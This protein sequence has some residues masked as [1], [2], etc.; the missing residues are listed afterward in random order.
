MEGS[1]SVK[2]IKEIEQ[3]LRDYPAALELYRTKRYKVKVKYEADVERVILVEKRSSR[4]ASNNVTKTNDHEKNKQSNNDTST[5]VNKTKD[6]VKKPKD[7]DRSRSRTHSQDRVLPTTSVS[8]NNDAVQTTTSSVR[9]ASNTQPKVDHQ[10]TPSKDR[11][12][13]EASQS[14]QEPQ[15]QQQE[16]RR[17]S[18]HRERSHDSRSNASCSKQKG[19]KCSRDYPTT[20]VPYIPNAN[21]AENMWHQ[22]RAL[23]PFYTN[24]L[25]QQQTYPQNM[26]TPSNYIAQQNPIYQQPY[27]YSQQNPYSLTYQQ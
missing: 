5:D 4:N 15:Q 16:Q 14:K 6:D 27:Y 19:R 7:S 9:V 17:N 25:F 24:P 26:Y 8:E 22:S 18:Y 12:I 1:R 23:Q 10:R 13:L 3:L 21:P 2:N 20:V 11:E